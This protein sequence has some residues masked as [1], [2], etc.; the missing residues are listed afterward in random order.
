[1]K[2]RPVGTELFRVEGQTDGLTDIFLSILTK[3]EFLEFSEKYSN[4]KF[5]ENP[6]S[7]NRVVPCVWTDGRTDRHILVRFERNLNFLDSF[8]ENIQIS[9]FI[10][11][12]PVGAELFHVDGQTDG[13]TDM[14]K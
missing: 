12:R 11:I 4:I 1:M 5:H 9:N 2:I 13:L 8:P 14:T 7:G 6:S 10:K 3:L